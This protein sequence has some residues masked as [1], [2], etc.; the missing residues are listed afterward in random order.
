MQ[1]LSQHQKLL[2]KLS[3]QQIKLMKLIQLPTIAL[4]QRVKQ[5]MEE[6]PAL[7][8]GSDVEEFDDDIYSEDGKEEDAVSYTHLTLPTI[9]SV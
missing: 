6:N 2:Q 8:E 7:E 5:E 4:E 3:P 9:Y 1:K